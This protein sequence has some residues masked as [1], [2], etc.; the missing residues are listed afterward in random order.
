MNVDRYNA[1]VG[2][3]VAVLTQYWGLLVSF[4][5]VSCA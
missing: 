3:A 1:A 2:A 4:C 5:R